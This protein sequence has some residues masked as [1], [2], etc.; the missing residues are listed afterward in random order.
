[1]LHDV[2]TGGRKQKSK[3]G[4]RRQKEAEAHLASAITQTAE[5]TFV[6][7]SKQ[8]FGRFLLDE[9]LPAIRG[10]IRPLTLARYE[11]IARTYVVKRDIGSVPLRVRSPAAI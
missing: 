6:E 3:G 9:W 7:A 5:G 11:K 8:P 4:F 2:E 1:M 10:T